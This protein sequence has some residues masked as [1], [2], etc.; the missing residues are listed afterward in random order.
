MSENKRYGA[1]LSRPHK[2]QCLITLLSCLHDRKQDRRQT[3][4]MTSVF[5]SIVLHDAQPLVAADSV[6]FMD[7]VTVIRGKL[8]YRGMIWSLRLLTSTLFQKT[9]ATFI[10]HSIEQ[11]DLNLFSAPLYCSALALYCNGMSCT[12]SSGTVLR[13]TLSAAE[14]CTAQDSTVQKQMQIQIQI[15]TVLYC[16]VVFCTVLYCSV[17]PHLHSCGP[18]HFLPAC[19]RCSY[20]SPP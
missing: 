18:P 14:Y 13:C 12:V 7:P 6:C 10:L 9:S 11:V 4:C 16:L 3:F 8:Q 19:V 20:C 2:T 1:G 15:Q 17:A 5:Y